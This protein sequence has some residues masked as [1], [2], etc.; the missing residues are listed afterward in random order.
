VC[1]YCIDVL[2]ANTGL[3][4][5]R[6]APFQSG[7]VHDDHDYQFDGSAERAGRNDSRRALGERRG[8]HNTMQFYIIEKSQRLFRDFH[9]QSDHGVERVDCAGLLS[10]AGPRSRDN[11][12]V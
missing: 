10:G 5:A 3:I 7:E 9:Q 1:D 11:D 12:A 2:L 4:L 6:R 8:Q